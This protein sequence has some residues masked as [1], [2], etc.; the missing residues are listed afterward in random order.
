MAGN[1]SHSATKRAFFF[2]SLVRNWSE[3][4]ENEKPEE[5]IVRVEYKGTQNYWGTGDNC[6][7]VGKVVGRNKWTLKENII[8][9]PHGDF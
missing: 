3:K 1:Y 2:V 6:R 9:S 4:G 8:L 7:F 5:K